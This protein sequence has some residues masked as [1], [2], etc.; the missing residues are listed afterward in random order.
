MIFRRLLSA[1]FIVVFFFVSCD[2]E[3]VFIRVTD[4]ST[5]LSSVTIIEGDMQILDAAVV[6]TNASNKRLI[7]SS[8]DESI[9]TVDNNGMINAIKVGNAVIT[10]RSED[11]NKS[12]II[13]VAVIES[14]LSLSQNVI[15][16]SI[17]GGTYNI[18]VSASNAWS[19]HSQPLWVSTSL[20]GGE[21]TGADS[22]TITVSVSQ[23]TGTSPERSGEIIFKLN[24]KDRTDTLTINQNNLQFSDGDYVKVQSSVKGNGIDL[25]FLGDGYTIEDVRTGKFDD[26]LNE[27]IYHFFDIE[28]FRTYRD[29][30]DVYIVYAYSEDSGISDHETTKNTKFSAKYESSNSTRMDIDHDVT[31]E[32]AKKAPLSSDLTETQITVITNSSRY[33]GTNWSYSDGMSISVVPV[34]NLQYP[35]DFR[36]LVQHEAAGH[37]FGRLA[38]EYVENYSTIPESVKDELRKWQGWGFFKNVDLT[39]DLNTILWKHLVEDPAYS[40][41]GAYEGGYTYAS[42]VWRPETTSLMTYNVKYINATGRELIVKKIKLL[43]GETY[44]FEEFKRND[45]RE[46][47]ALTRSAQ[48]TL[49]RSLRLLPPI[50]IEVN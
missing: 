14:W 6:P 48:T 33:A 7:W 10:V 8:S 47:Q 41:V 2:K 13:N 12:V 24:N 36:G 18:K 32:Y 34:S 50:L 42:G 5:N 37:G 25:V 29:Y 1:I 26:N 9:V 19:I 20:E 38:D 4:V 44:S 35:N 46:A 39:N 45:I 16:S 30:F 43:A 23:F 22:V 28:P 40:Y 3:E 49:D 27:A 15:E 17:K 31:F 11:G 21:A